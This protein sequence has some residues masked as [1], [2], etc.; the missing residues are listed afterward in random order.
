MS[1]RPAA[2]WRASGAA[3]RTVSGGRGSLRPPQATLR[4]RAGRVWMGEQR[5]VVPALGETARQHVDD[6]L[7]AAVVHGRHRH[8]RVDGEGDAQRPLALQRSV[9]LGHFCGHG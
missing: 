7:D 3:L 2:T 5:H 6:A 9:E 8:L 1:K 4:H